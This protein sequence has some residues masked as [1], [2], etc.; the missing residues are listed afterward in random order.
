LTKK[1]IDL[2]DEY[3]LKNKIMTLVEDEGSNLNTIPSAFKFV[4]KCE[5]LGL[6]ENFQETC[7]EHDFFKAWQYATSDEKT[8]K[9]LKCAFMKST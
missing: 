1:L 2:L 4:V 6:K 9:G 3:G 5:A 8:C 7:F